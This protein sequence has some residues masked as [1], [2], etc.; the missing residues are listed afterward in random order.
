[1]NHVDHLLVVL[2]ISLGLDVVLGLPEINGKWLL[3]E[4][5]W[6]ILM[7]HLDALLSLVNIFVADVTGLEVDKGL[8]G[9]SVGL[10]EILD[11]NR[12]NL[13]SFA[14][15]FLNLFFSNFLWDELNEKV[16]LIGLLHILSDLWNLFTND[17]VCL[18]N[19]LLN[20]NSLSIDFL[21]S[22]QLID[23]FLGIIMSL[24]L[25]KPTSL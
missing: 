9:S 21:L 18:G 12:D 22:I 7:E 17:I 11:F 20:E 3:S 5:E 10:N 8:T 23:S 13:T 2:L 15:L 24:I 1:M 19:V 16:R 6:L 25:N 4:T 14:E